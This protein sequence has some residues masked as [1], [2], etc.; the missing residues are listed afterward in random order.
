MPIPV[1]SLQSRLSRWRTLTGPT[2]KPGFAFQINVVDPEALPALPVWRELA[3]ERLEQAWKSYEKRLERMTWLDDD[4]LPYLHIDTGTEIFAEAFGSSVHRP[5]DNKPFAEPFIHSIS[6]IDKV[7]DPE[8]STSS[9]AYLFD[10]MDELRRRSGPD[11]LVRII[12]IQSPVDIAAL[13]LEKSQF[14]M[15][16]IEDP[17]AVLALIAKVERLLVAFLDEWFRR[18]GTT[19]IAHYPDYP[20]FG[21]LTLSEDDVGSF[22]ADM[23]AT[24]CKPVLTRLSN[25]YGG[26]GIHC[27]ADSRHQWE[28]FSKLPGLRMMNFVK[29]HKRTPE[30]FMVPSYEFFG[31]I[32]AQ[33]PQG[34]APFIGEPSTWPDRYPKNS[35]VVMNL[36]AKDPEEAKRLA[37]I[38]R[39]K[40]AQKG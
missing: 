16:M 36:S 26:I 32:C 38:M 9:L 13:I 35:R 24:F 21:G 27:C 39:E 1:A 37:A 18:Y 11:A 23:F 20:M 2:P 29:P 5:S 22:D 6:D 10:L 28:H 12:D 14:F 33:F 19:F 8:L 15:A 17:Q 4:A 31:P 3:E 34:E 30:E 7:P 40:Q 25:R